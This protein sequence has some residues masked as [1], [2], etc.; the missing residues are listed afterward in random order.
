METSLSCGY[1]KP[2]LIRSQR[3]QYIFFGAIARLSFYL[4]HHQMARNGVKVPDREL[5]RRQRFALT[6]VS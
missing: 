5:W 3:F 4:A 6:A 2:F 1:S